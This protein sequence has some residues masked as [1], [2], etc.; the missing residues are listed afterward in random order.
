MIF[1]D[2]EDSGDEAEHDD[3]EHDGSGGS[4][5]HAESGSGDDSN[6]S[7]SRQSGR[8]SVS[9]GIR[10]HCNGHRDHYDGNDSLGDPYDSAEEDAVNKGGCDHG[11]SNCLESEY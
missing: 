9:G 7:S 3:D 1:S 8:S 2:D 4:E 6:A 5:D 11:A 10:F